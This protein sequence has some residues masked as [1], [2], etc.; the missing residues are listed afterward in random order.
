MRFTNPVPQFWLDNGEIASSGKMYFYENGDYSTL[1]DTYSQSDNTVP[2]TNPVILD[3]QGRMPSC[4]GDGF[5]SVKFY[6]ADGVLQW[7][8]DDVALSDGSGQMELWLPAVRYTINDIVKDPSDGEYY[9]LY[10][11]PSSLGN[12]PS[13]SLNLWQKIVFISEFNDNKTYSEDEIVKYGGFLY[14]S[15][16]DNNNDTPPSSKWANLTFNDSVAGDFSVG[17]AL[18]VGSFAN[19]AEVKTSLR[20]AQQGSV[21]AA[22][23]YL[24]PSLT[25]SALPIGWYEVEAAIRFTTS[26]STSNGIK[27]AILDLSGNVYAFGSFGV[28]DFIVSDTQSES[29]A[30]LNGV[31]VEAYPLS[32]ATSVI[33]CKAMINNTAGS[34]I[35][36]GWSQATT[37]PANATL[38]ERAY[39]K[40]TRLKDL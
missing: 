35:V 1:K 15:L 19:F 29:S 3:G 38:V 6:S 36:I 13:S 2:N 7:T 26:G 16:E 17:G 37:T 39:V 32:N 14:R 28:W 31:E 20:T 5:Y 8:R 40:A 23:Y 11:S 12:Q 22:S 9:Q 21:T 25:I 33:K 18:T 4:F 30:T 34:G 27:A 24:D 10:G